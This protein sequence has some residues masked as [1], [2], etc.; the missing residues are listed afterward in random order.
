MSTSGCFSTETITAGLAHVAA[1]AALHL[2]GEV[3]LGD[4]AQVDRRA[5]STVR[6]DE[7][8]QVV[9]A[10]GPADVPDQ[11]FAGVL[12]GEAAAGVGAELRQRR[13][14]LRVW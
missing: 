4:L 8:A 5:S 10:H 7:A 13:L 6:D 9:E 11:V 1:V 14:D 2:G 12:V 3:D